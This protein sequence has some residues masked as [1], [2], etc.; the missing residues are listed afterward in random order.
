LGERSGWHV[1]VYGDEFVNCIWEAG[2][3][4]WFESPTLE[5][6]LKDLDESDIAVFRNIKNWQEVNL[7]A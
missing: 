4:I 3:V 6:E 2:D 7:E 5:G 1:R